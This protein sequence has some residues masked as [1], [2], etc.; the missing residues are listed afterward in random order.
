M[1]SYL[2]FSTAGKLIAGLITNIPYYDFHF[3]YSSVTD[4]IGDPFY[5]YS[6]H[7]MPCL[8]K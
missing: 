8:L 6:K 1:I 4:C 5:N 3:I 7:L 2:E